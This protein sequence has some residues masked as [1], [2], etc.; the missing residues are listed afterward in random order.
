MGHC[1]C[2]SEDMS[3]KR[4]SPTGGPAHEVSEGDEPGPKEAVIIL[5]F[6][7][8]YYLHACEVC[9]VCMHV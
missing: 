7:F 1:G 5:K 9:M 2:N 4:N 6:N 8:I 3:V